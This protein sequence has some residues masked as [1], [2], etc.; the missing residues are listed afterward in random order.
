MTSDS[1]L[2]LIA[3]GRLPAA[4]ALDPGG[5]PCWRL[6]SLLAWMRIDRAEFVSMLPQRSEIRRVEDMGIYSAPTTRSTT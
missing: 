1:D 5:A 3:A 6:D 4:D 2:S